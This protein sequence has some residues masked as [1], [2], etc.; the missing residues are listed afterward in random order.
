LV[1]DASEKPDPAT[2]LKTLL[3]LKLREDFEDFQ[4]LEQEKKDLVV[5]QHYRSLLKHIFDILIQEGV[6]FAAPPEGS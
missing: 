2:E 5:Q 6:S 4:A 1:S 3:G